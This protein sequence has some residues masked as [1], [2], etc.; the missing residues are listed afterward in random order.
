M[1]RSP[2][3]ILKARGKRYDVNTVRA[4]SSEGSLVSS[5]A[6]ETWKEIQLLQLRIEVRG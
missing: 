4:D 3:A 1:R 2:Y 5:K 6:K